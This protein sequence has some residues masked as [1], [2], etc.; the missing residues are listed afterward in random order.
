MVDRQGNAGP[1][2]IWKNTQPRRA[3]R[4]VPARNVSAAICRVARS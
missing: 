2:V 3:R 1:A 4:T